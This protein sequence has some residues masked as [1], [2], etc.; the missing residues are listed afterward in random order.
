MP[1]GDGRSSRPRSTH[2]KLFLGHFRQKEI[3]LYITLLKLSEIA[4]KWLL[5][6][7]NRY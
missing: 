4:L 5:R 7:P 1:E 2:F 3:E 6:G